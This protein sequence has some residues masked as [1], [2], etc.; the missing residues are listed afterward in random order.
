MSPLEVLHALPLFYHFCAVY[1]V[2]HDER[3]VLM[4]ALF[5]PFPLW[6]TVWETPSLEAV[7]L[8]S[9]HR[10]RVVHT[11]KT[12]KQLGII[13]GSSLSTALTKAPD[14]EAVE[15]ASPYLT[16]SWEGLVEEL[17]GLTRT[18]ETPAQGRLLM[19]LEPADAAQL[20]ESYRVR[21][22]LAESVEI[23]VIAA[24]ISSPGKVRQ[25]ATDRQEALLD[26]LPLYILKCLG[27]SVGTLERLTWLGLKRV[28]QLRAW[29]KVQVSAYLGTEAKTLLPYLFGPYRTQLGRYTPAPRISA[30]LAFDEPLSEPRMLHLAVEKLAA[31]LVALLD[32]KTASRLTVIALGYG[33]ELKATRLSKAPLQR[34][35]ETTRLAFLT[36]EDTRAQPLGIEALALELSGLTRPA[37]Q[38]RLWPQKERLEEAV[39]AVE[40]RFPKAILKLVEDDPYALASEHSVRFV[41]LST[42]EEVTREAEALAPERADQRAGQ[43]L[44]A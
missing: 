36:L 42:G 19:E 29:K 43:P 37:E 30:T 40:A 38:G 23:A 7:P 27:L 4:A 3:A 21:V 2:W 28:G 13:P 32:G 11:S 15:A 5:E 26:A 12:A 44:E 6:L 10:G 31:E 24:L 33:L 17:S 1:A 20:A 14:L 22:G 25:V 34:L 18:L 41:V 35:A 16:A 39:A 9:L 8:V